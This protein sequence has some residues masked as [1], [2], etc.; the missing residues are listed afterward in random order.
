[1]SDIPKELVGI[2][3]HPSFPKLVEYLRGSIPDRTHRRFR[4][5]EGQSYELHCAE[6]GG[7]ELSLDTLAG[8]PSALERQTNP[9][10]TTLERIPG[11][12][13][14]ETQE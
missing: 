6:A 8:L 2:I 14:N 9:K 1:M 5:K 10:R 13:T 12:Y 4:A 7:Y 3:T 11:S